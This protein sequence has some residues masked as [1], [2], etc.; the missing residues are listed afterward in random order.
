M[1]EI[2]NSGGRVLGPF[3]SPREAS[4]RATETGRPGDVWKVRV[5]V[6]EPREL[7]VASGTDVGAVRGRLAA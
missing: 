2:V 7:G 5:F 3:T 4:Q 6:A 1:W